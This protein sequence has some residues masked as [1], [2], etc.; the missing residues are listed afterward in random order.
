VFA[1]GAS[2]TD[3]VAKLTARATWGQP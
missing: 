2:Y 3:C 1:H